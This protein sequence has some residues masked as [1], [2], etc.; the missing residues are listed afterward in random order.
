MEKI[1]E[2]NFKYCPKCGSDSFSKKGT[3]FSCEN[4]GFRFYINAAAAVAAIIVDNTGKILLAVRGKDPLKGAYDLPG[5][6]IDIGE[7]AEEALKREIKEELDLEIIESYF[8]AS[9]PNTY[10]Y[11]G[12]IYFPLDIGFICKVSGMENIKPLDDVAG[13]EFIHPKEIDL[14]KI[15]F[16]SARNIVRTYCKTL[17]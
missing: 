16:E 15:G 10:E 13:F 11:K 1:S 3:G 2:N 14:S 6:F 12:M 9:F 4:C 7:T 8:L 5:G 17:N